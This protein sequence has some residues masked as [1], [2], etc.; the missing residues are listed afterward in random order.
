MKPKR[1]VN[2]TSKRPHKK[3]SIHIEN[4]ILLYEYSFR[5][6]L[7]ACKYINLFII[8]WH[9]ND[10]IVT[11]R[12]LQSDFLFSLHS[13]LFSLIIHYYSSILFIYIV[14]I[15]QNDEFYHFYT[16]SS[17]H[18]AIYCSPILISIWMFRSDIDWLIA[19]IKVENCYLGISLVWCYWYFCLFFYCRFLH[20]IELLLVSNDLQTV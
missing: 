6:V 10:A 8:C 14:C 7:C 9:R 11:Y 2:I 3:S 19:G 20:M 12:F 15:Y 16:H 13:S 1:N 18:G 17:S 5:L 4:Y